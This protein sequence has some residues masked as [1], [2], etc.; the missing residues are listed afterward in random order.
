MSARRGRSSAAGGRIVRFLGPALLLWAC[1]G[2]AAQPDRLLAAVDHLVYA[3]PD[4]QRGVDRVEKLLGVRATAGGQHPGRGTRNALLSFGPTSYLEII[5]PDPEQPTPALPRPFGIDGLREPRL[6]A[7]AAKATALEQLAADAVR[8][9]V[10][11]GEVIAGSRRRTDG[12]LLT[13][14][15]TDPRTVV[16][17]GLVPFFIDW[18]R[19]PHPA[20]SAAPGATLVALR[21]EHPDAQRVHNALNRVGVE[22][23]VRQGPRAA[24]I[25]TIEGPRGRVELR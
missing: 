6:V 2:T 20:A 3:T 9:G 13:W 24:L 25:A 22:L 16:A 21:A 23:P 15:Y 7:W 17:D 11:L 19:T 12:V 10:T 18:G 14:R 1:T 5:G 8:G 4:L